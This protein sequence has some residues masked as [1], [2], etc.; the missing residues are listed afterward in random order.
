L[1][2]AIEAVYFVYE[3]KFKALILIPAL[4]VKTLIR[5]KQTSGTTIH[6]GFSSLQK[7]SFFTY[8]FLQNMKNLFSIQLI[9]MLLFMANCR[10]KDENLIP[11]TVVTNPSI[12]IKDFY[13]NTGVGST[14]ST[15]VFYDG[16]SV[17]QIIMVLP[18]KFVGDEITPIIKLAEEAE[19]ISPKSGEKVFF[20]GKPAIE[21]TLTKK[22]G[23]TEKYFLY[24]QR[25]E[26]LKV[27]MLTKEI[28][29][30]PFDYN[31][32]K[33][34]IFNIGTLNTPNDPNGTLSF[35]IE[36]YSSDPKQRFQFSGIFRKEPNG[37]IFTVGLKSKKIGKISLKVVA[38]LPQS[39]KSNSLD[40]L[41]V[42]G[43]KSSIT[44]PFI[45]FN[46]GSIS[47]I[48]GINFD[49]LKK[50]TIRLTNDFLD[51]EFDYPL[52]YVDDVTLSFDITEKLAN[53]GYR[54]SFYEKDS[55]VF[56]SEITLKGNPQYFVPFQTYFKKVS[57]LNNYPQ[58]YELNDKLTFKPGGDFIAFERAFS[59]IKGDLKLINY[60]TK[61][62][63]ILKGEPSYCCDGSITYRIFTLPET[64]PVGDYEIYGII[65]GETSARYS[66]KLT[67]VEK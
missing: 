53:V 2:L 26:E 23:K 31:M 63:F 67:I 25:R 47:Y 57:P 28:A 58:P 22:D 37:N 65:E 32:L 18:E 33:V 48:D 1:G 12:P 17:N 21:Y 56:Y 46:M 16:D 40:L 10:K 51:K 27:E 3:Y 15:V 30:D 14:I 41:L 35:Q 64:I 34:R 11:Q 60:E 54:A 43:E 4:R 19:S 42:R 24:V 8:S 62:E 55:L 66:R 36:P 61:K 50:Y 52:K 6:S 7:L 5:Q 59:T 49:P 44:I 29:I 45:S 13:L 20:E 38:N 39:R 9:L